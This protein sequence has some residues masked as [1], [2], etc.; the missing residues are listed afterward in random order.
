MTKRGVLLLLLGGVTSVQV[1][2]R[3]LWP[4]ATLLHVCIILSR[5]CTHVQLPYIWD[6]KG[7]KEVLWVRI[8]LFRSVC[9]DGS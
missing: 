9:I 1:L 2:K 5:S 6:P 4:T 7:L 3:D 8:L